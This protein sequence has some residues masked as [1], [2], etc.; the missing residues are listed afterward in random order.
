MIG[1]LFLLMAVQP[2]RDA[3]RAAPDIVV[4][5]EGSVTVLPNTFRSATKDGGF[6]IQ[7]AT[8]GIYVSTHVIYKLKP[9]ERVRVTGR[10]QED[11]HG[12]RVIKATA[13][14]KLKGLVMM[15]QPKRVP[16][17]SVGIENQ[18]ELI[19][20]QGV[21][22]RI[23]RDA[24]YGMGIFINDG[25]GDVQVY[26]HQSAPIG[27]LDLFQ[28]GTRIG[29]TGF[30]GQYDRYVEVCPRSVDDIRENPPQ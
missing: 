12:L 30:S 13:V 18:G 21:I 24:P 8:G 29:V 25:S 20:V 6:A 14:Q 7:D 27:T 19:T 26:I 1:L 22:N 15:I 10:I 9:F 11:G 16:T 23:R 4:T 28:V 17:G 2:I 5:I 3:R